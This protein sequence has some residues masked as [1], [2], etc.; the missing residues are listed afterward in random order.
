MRITDRHFFFH[1][2][3]AILYNAAAGLLIYNHKQDVYLY[4]SM[5][6]LVAGSHLIFLIFT[7]LLR[8]MKI[9]SIGNMGYTILAVLMINVIFWLLLLSIF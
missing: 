5:V 2:L 8:I 6:A 1:N 7:A 4:T 3:A 9:K